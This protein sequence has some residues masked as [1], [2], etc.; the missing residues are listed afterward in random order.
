MNK[1]EKIEFQISTR[2]K[3]AEKIVMKIRSAFIFID[4]V[5]FY[6]S[7]HRIDATQNT[8][9]NTN[10][11][12]DIMKQELNRK[13]TAAAN[14]IV[15][16]KATFVAS[17]MSDIFDSESTYLMIAFLRKCSKTLS[18]LLARNNTNNP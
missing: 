3:Y 2:R 5:G 15:N 17:P 4:F 8:Q 9:F 11:S 14:K 16:K 10:N 18:L 12:A 13:N 7:R 6:F 1:Q